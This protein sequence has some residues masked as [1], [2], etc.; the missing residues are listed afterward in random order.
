MARTDIHLDAMLR[1]LNA[2]S[3]ESPH[4]PQK[5]RSASCVYT[6]HFAGGKYTRSGG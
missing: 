3:H 5:T 2:A 4:H 1:H 6:T